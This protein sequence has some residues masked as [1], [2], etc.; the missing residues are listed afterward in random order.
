MSLRRVALTVA[1]MSLVA[2]PAYAGDD[3]RAPTYYDMVSTAPHCPLGPFSPTASLRVAFTTPNFLIQE[4]SAGMHYNGIDPAYLVDMAP[5]RVVDGWIARP[6]GPSLGDEPA[7]RRAAES[8]HAWRSPIRRHD[9][10]SF[11][12]W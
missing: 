12:E 11:A 8:G 4:Q 3:R 6:T 2:S 5:V 10:G 7:V 9:D 1:L